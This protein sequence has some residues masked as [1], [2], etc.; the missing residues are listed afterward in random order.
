MYLSS[1][2]EHDHFPLQWTF[3]G[4][5]TVPTCVNCHDLKDRVPL[6]SWPL[7]AVAAG[8][9]E[10]GEELVPPS[11]MKRQIL[12]DGAPREYPH[13]LLTHLR[14]VVV[15][16]KW[17]SLSPIAR[18]LVAKLLVIDQMGRHRAWHTW[19]AEVEDAEFQPGGEKG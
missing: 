13:W 12:A 11:E 2:H 4:E 17:Q 10:V 7:I 15:Q 9:E 19:S 1:R 3:G 16:E 8:F 18:I 14:W 6:L 5:G